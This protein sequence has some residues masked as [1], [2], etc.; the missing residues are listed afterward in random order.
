[1]GNP[2]LFFDAAVRRP[3]LNAGALRACNGQGLLT[4]KA[5]L[6]FT[7]LHFRKANSVATNLRC[8]VA[9]LMFDAKVPVGA[10]DVTG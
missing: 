2:F 9:C 1:L 5:V 6:S 4:A 7:R 10:V 8:I 3:A